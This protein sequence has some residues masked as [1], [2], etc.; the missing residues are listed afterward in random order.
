MPFSQLLADGTAERG[1][2]RL[3]AA[4]MASSQVPRKFHEFQRA[5][6]SRVVLGCSIELS[7]HAVRIMVGKKREEEASAAARRR[8]APNC[9][10]ALRHRQRHSEALKF[11]SSSALLPWR[12]GWKSWRSPASCRSAAPTSTCRP[13]QRHL[14]DVAVWLTDEDSE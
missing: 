2:D 11:C 13:P 10:A 8:G 1:N 3:P 6:L 5:I 4:S 12:G 9:G 14:R 7:H